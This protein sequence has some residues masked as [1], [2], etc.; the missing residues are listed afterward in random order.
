[1]VGLTSEPNWVISKEKH[2]NTYCYEPDSRTFLSNEKI[3]QIKIVSKT[4]KDKEKTIIILHDRKNGD[5]HI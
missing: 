2:M 1:M 4:G 3:K 5:L